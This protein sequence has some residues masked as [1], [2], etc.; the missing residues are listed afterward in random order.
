MEP[1]RHSEN[2]THAD[3]LYIPVP[4]FANAPGTQCVGTATCIDHPPTI[5]LSRIAGALPGSPSPSSVSNVPIPAHDH[6]VG[7]RNSGL[8]EWWNVKVIATTDPATFNTLTS[9]GAINTALANSTA[10]MAP[11]NTF[12]FFQVLPGTL[13][14]SMAADLTATAPPGSGVAPAP[15][16][17]PAANQVEAGH[18]LQQSEE[19]LRRNCTAVPEHRHQP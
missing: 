3:T 4:L 9:V 2:T 18:Y 19:R 7:T 16:P 12:L 17:S 10:I 6:V 14:A 8:P 5:D 15:D 1:V 11:T 13:S